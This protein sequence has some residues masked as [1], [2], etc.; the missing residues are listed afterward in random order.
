MVL[1]LEIFDEGG[2]VFGVKVFGICNEGDWS[3]GNLV[4]VCVSCLVG[5]VGIGII[6]F[7]CGILLF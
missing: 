7:S 3:V 6:I 5:F 1:G 4:G 2:W